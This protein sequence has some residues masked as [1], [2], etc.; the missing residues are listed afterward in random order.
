MLN[1]FASDIT[2]VKQTII[3]KHLDD[4]KAKNSKLFKDVSRMA[5]LFQEIG[6]PFGDTNTLHNIE[7]GEQPPKEVVTDLRRI[8]ELGK[9]QYKEY[10]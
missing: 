4:T 9:T 1:D 10:F 5:T 7:T 3:Q 6:N 2:N 8:D